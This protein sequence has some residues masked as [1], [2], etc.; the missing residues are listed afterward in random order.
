MSAPWESQRMRAADI[1]ETT[2]AEWKH[3][4]VTEVYLQF[5]E[6]QHKAW[7]ELAADLV[8]LGALD[9]TST[10]EDRNPHVVR[11]KLAVVADLAQITIRAIQGFYAED[12]EEAS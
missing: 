11:G 12:G 4:P 10:H 1:S 2:F 5:L 3:H 8:E 6:D 9:P 7:R